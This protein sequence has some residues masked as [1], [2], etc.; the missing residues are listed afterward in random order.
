M[1]TELYRQIGASEWSLVVIQDKPGGPLSP[2]ILQDGR[3]IESYAPI[4]DTE[5][6][7]GFLSLLARGP[8]LPTGPHC[9]DTP[10]HQTHTEQSAPRDA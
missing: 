9:R 8:R 6:L 2:V 7:A 3:V 10:S 4:A 5:A 1:N